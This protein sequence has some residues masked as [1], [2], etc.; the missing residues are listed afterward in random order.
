MT[1]VISDIHGCYQE[2]LAL[3]EKIG[4]SDS[5]ELYVL[6]DMV[7]RGPEPIKVL[8]DMMARPNVYPILG[9]HDYMALTMLSKLNVEITAENAETH[10]TADDITGYLHW[11]QDGGEVTARQFRALPSEQRQDILDYLADCT[12]YELVQAGG[13]NYVLVHAGLN[14]FVPGK[15]LDDYHYSDLIFHRADYS[16]RCFPKWNTYLVT[17]HTP[18]MSIREDREPLVYEGYGHIA[19]DCGC[20]FG[21]QLAAYCLETQKAVYVRRKGN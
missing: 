12:L 14:G 7:D 20:V 5:D 1:Y 17:G 21:G 19:V 9:N 8:L 13:N 4:F 18:T 2:Y 15:D 16:R 11:T 6:G 10:L 3:L